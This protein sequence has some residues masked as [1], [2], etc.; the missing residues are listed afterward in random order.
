[1]DGE[2]KFEDKGRLY[3]FVINSLMYIMLGTH[4]NIAIAV[5][6]LSRF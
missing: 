4:L 1:M 6:L 5:N 2:I 3:R